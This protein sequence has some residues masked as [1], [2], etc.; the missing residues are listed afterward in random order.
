MVVIPK[1]TLEEVH[2]PRASVVHPAR[3][4]HS[5]ELWVPQSLRE[6]LQLPPRVHPTVVPHWLLESPKQASG[7]PVHVPAGAP[8]APG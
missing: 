7:S 8:P 1:Q 4:T 6:P 2:I 5:L 3:Y